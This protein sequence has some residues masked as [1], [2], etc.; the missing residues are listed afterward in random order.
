MSFCHDRRKSQSSGF[1]KQRLTLRFFNRHLS[2]AA[3]KGETTFHVYLQGTH[4]LLFW[5]C[6]STSLGHRR[7]P[8]PIPLRSSPSVPSSNLPSSIRR[9]SY[10]GSPGL[11]VVQA[12]VDSVAE[13][14]E[15]AI[16]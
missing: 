10:T 3:I 13:P 12:W 5:V 4:L 16:L 8:R 6:E 2:Q 14:D 11:A 7:C 1:E 9:T 15:T